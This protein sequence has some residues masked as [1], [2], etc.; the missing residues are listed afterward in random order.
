MCIIKSINANLTWDFITM[1]WTLVSKS[2]AGN[3][4]KFAAIGV[5]SVPQNP[6]VIA[7]AEATIGF[8]HWANTKGAPIPTVITENAA[9]ALPIIIVNIAIPI[10]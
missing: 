1:F 5:I 4:L 6:V 7:R 10:Q 2:A 3:T 8:P 9:K